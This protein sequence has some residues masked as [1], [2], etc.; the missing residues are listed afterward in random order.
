MD[1]NSDDRQADGL[2]LFKVYE[3][4]EDYKLDQY[5]EYVMLVG[6]EEGIA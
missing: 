4:V 6:A 2:R 1:K 3:L 5:F